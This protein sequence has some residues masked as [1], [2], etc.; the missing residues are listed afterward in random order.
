[1]AQVYYTPGVYIEEKNAFANSVVPV[2]T[3]VPAFVGYTEFAQRGRTLLYNVPTRIA[4]FAE[5]LEL[6][7]GA[8]EVTFTLTGGTGTDYTLETNASTQFFLFRAMQLFFSNGGSVCYIVSVA[9]YD[10]TNGVNATL[11]NNLSTQGG[12]AS[13]NKEQEPTMVVIPDAVLLEASECYSL[14]QAMLLHCGQDTRSRVALLDVHDGYKDHL[15]GDDVITD[16]RNGVG[17]NFLQ[18]GAAYYPWVNAT[19][20][21]A[22]QV[23]YTSI[24]N[25]DALADLLDREVEANLQSGFIKENKANDTKA[26]INELRGTV[27]NTETLGNALKSL[28]PTYRSILKDMQAKLNLLP[29]SGGMAG[30]ICMVDNAVGVFKSPANVSMGAV[31][32]PAVNITNETQENLNMPLNGKAVNAIRTFVGKGVLVWGARTLDGNSND[33]RYLNVRRTMIYLEQSVKA[34]CEAYVFEPNDATT[35]VR[36]KA[37]IDSF[38]RNQWSAGALA[39]TTPEDAYRVDV[40]LGITMTPQDI[41]DGYMR[42]SVKVAISRPAEF[43]VITFQ[44]QMQK[45]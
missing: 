16:F 34:A 11:L 15:K 14:Q 8:P 7:G 45:S 4:S 38:L 41:L 30:V 25:L 27:A 9:P 24:V 29:P 33:W 23:R 42:V 13:L 43:I 40:G 10:Y 17:I 3:A 21:D 6:F 2:A 36:V 22:A 1:M 28:S 5:Y 18:F 12:L 26:V 35:W 20:V 19:V 32:S 39:G 44:Q 31:S 37:M